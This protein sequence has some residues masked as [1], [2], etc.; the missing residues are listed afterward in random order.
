M[1]GSTKEDVDIAIWDDVAVE[2]FLLVDDFASLVIV[3]APLV[4]GVGK[5]AI[6]I[7][8]RGGRCS[9]GSGSSRHVED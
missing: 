9:R 3:A 8:G 4:E 7:F 6:L 5:L 2:K 1:V